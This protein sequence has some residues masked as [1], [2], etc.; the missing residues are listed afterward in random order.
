METCKECL[1]KCGMLNISCVIPKCT[2]SG[3]LS[4]QCYFRHKYHKHLDFLESDGFEHIK[5]CQI[6]GYSYE[7]PLHVMWYE[8]D[9]TD[10]RLIRFLDRRSEPNFV[11]RI[12]QFSCCDSCYHQL[13]NITYHSTFLYIIPTLIPNITKSKSYTQ[14]KPIDD[15]L[16]G[17]LIFKSLY[18]SLYKPSTE[19][20]YEHESGYPNSEDIIIEHKF[21]YEEY[22]TKI[23]PYIDRI[24]YYV[25]LSI[26]ENIDVKEYFE[27]LRCDNQT[28]CIIADSIRSR[29]NKQKGLSY[30]AIQIPKPLV[31]I[32]MSYYNQIWKLI[33]CLKIMEDE[34]STPYPKGFFD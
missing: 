19:T 8:F 2:E 1:T 20:W 25:G 4:K 11:T 5:E 24:I 23:I 32:I 18:I 15:F 21:S 28:M 10:N 16:K 12:I 13:N 26:V 17:R 33:E 3:F 34:M 27:D 9:T 29:I 30:E 7:K 14:D 22:I 31:D 6:C